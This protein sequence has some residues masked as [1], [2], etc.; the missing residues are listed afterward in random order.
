MKVNGTIKVIFATN[1]VS[2]KFSKRDLVVTTADM[3]PQDILIQFTQDKCNV[4]DSYN[5][6]EVVEV[7]INLRGREWIN[8]QGEAKYF[9]TIEGWKIAKVG[10]VA[11][12]PPQYKAQPAQA[13]DVDDDLPF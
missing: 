11:Q 5:A 8:P 12:A 13:V 10:S 2:D 9:T 4:L 6:G 7:D 1:V 3:Y